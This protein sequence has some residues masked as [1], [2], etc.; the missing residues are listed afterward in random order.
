MGVGFAAH[1]LQLAQAVA[2]AAG[3]AGA[4]RA[5][6]AA[7]VQSFEAAVRPLTALPL[8]SAGDPEEA[9]HVAI[10]LRMLGSI[11]RV[12]AC[13][14]AEIAACARLPPADAAALAAF[15]AGGQSANEEAEGAPACSMLSL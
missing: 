8:S 11:A 10:M 4:W 13:G 1:A 9:V 12:S 14:A 2:G 5:A 7:R 15:F 6:Q 3:A